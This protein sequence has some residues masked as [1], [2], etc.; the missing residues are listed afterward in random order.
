[1]VTRRTAAETS[2][3]TDRLERDVFCNQCRS[4]GGLTLPRA[5]ASRAEATMAR[6]WCSKSRLNGARVQQYRTPCWETKTW[7]PDS[8]R[9]APPNAHE[10]AGAAR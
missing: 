3:H 7:Q 6:Q 1:M 2:P 10:R 9:P 5:V 4:R 8:D